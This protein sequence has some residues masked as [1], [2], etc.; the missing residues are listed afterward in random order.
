MNKKLLIVLLCL[1]SVSLAFG[2][3]KNEQNKSSSKI[4]IIGHVVSKGNDPF[5]YPVIRAQD[6]T[7]YMIVCT[8]KTKKKLLNAQ[9]YKIKFTG[10]LEDG[11][12]V[13][14]KWKKV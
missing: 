8:N 6:G 3:Q 13:L 4:E 1:F 5:I 14:K 12:F 11:M 7:E 10:K 2:L 9:G